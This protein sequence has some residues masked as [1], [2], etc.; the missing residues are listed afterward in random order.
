[1]AKSATQ[2]RLVRM[3][4]VLGLVA[5]GFG[6]IAVNAVAAPSSPER[7]V[8]LTIP[9][10]S[11][12]FNATTWSTTCASQG[13]C[14]TASPSASLASVTVTFERTSDH[15]FWT[16]N[17][18]TTPRP[19]A[20]QT[21]GGANWVLPFPRRPLDGFYR[22]VVTA[23][24]IAGTTRPTVTTSRQL[25]ILTS[26]PPRPRVQGPAESPVAQSANFSVST[27][28]LYP[29]SFTCD[30]DHE[31]EQ[32]GIDPSTKTNERQDNEIHFSCGGT[33]HPTR[34]RF[35]AITAQS[36]SL[37]VTPTVAGKSCVDAVAVDVAGNR[38][39]MQST[40]FSVFG[41]ALAVLHG[42]EA[43]A[44]LGQRFDQPIVVALKTTSGHPVANAPVTFAVAH[45]A[46]A[47]S[48]VDCPST[49]EP[50]TCSVTTDAQGMATLPALVAGQVPGPFTVV[51]S[52]PG[53]SPVGVTVYSVV[54]FTMA[55]AP[56][57]PLMPGHSIA[58]NLQLANANAVPLTVK[59]GSLSIKVTPGLPSCSASQFSLGRNLGTNVVLPA[60]STV[61]LSGLHLALKNWPTL[62]MAETGTSQDA[63]KGVHLALTLSGV[64]TG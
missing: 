19:F 1:M 6:A 31:T 2:K 56:S 11:A 16:G 7:S 18:F 64:A 12:A 17:D 34:L 43:G 26:T 42:Q 48:V 27:R 57:T 58:L 9:N 51:A 46:A 39:D 29:V 36:G 3:L 49:G 45:G 23:T 13:L 63:C 24:Y 47:G 61:T 37:N 35:D 28:Y 25:L 41:V 59:K 40:C 30:V 32:V 4:P 21:T 38:S 8:T 20:L 10:A 33:P 50:G 5:V 22:A 14:G 53:A 62:A 60:K 44:Q 54:P 55:V 52:A 15:R